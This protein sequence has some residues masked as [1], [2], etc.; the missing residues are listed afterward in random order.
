MT[1]TKMIHLLPPFQTCRTWWHKCQF[2]CK[3]PTWLV[4]TVNLMGFIITVETN[5]LTVTI[6]LGCINS[7]AGDSD[8]RKRRKGGEC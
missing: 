5:F 8:C 7:W 6:N 4:L 3:L 1:T 2:G